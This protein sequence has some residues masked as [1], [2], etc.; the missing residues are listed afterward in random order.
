M[1]EC[2]A[3]D[4]EVQYD[5]FPHLVDHGREDHPS[6]FDPSLGSNWVVRKYISQT[7]AALNES[8]EYEPP[9]NGWP[10][11]SH[12]REQ[13]PIGSD[14]MNRAVDELEDRGIVVTT[15]SLYLD[16]MG[17]CVQTIQ[18]TRLTDIAQDDETPQRRRWV[19]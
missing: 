13:L 11:K 2:P 9:V 10:V 19:G 18:L 3:D 8:D 1:F 17:G 7:I 12:V 14:R 16:Q 6:R 15:P 5:H 4:C